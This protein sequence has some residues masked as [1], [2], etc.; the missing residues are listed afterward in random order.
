MEIGVC[1]CVCARACVCLCE[2]KRVVLVL[3]CKRETGGTLISA[4]T[5]HHRIYHSTTVTAGQGTDV[6]VYPGAT[7]D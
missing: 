6:S 3:L 1:V 2:R 5:G 4:G 7:S